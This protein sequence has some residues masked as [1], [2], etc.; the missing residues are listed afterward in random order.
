MNERMTN[1]KPAHF[2]GS[3]APTST[4][5]NFEL[6]QSFPSFLGLGSSQVLFRV[7]VPVSP[8]DFE[9][10]DQ[11]DHLFQCPSTGS[12]KHKRPKI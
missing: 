2:G 9:H 11:S 3:Q 12:I 1:D 4:S 6:S 8:H 5:P 10:S 7:R